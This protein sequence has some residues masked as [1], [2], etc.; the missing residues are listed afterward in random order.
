MAATLERAS[1]GWVESFET[2][3]HHTSQLKIRP[4]HPTRCV[5]PERSDLAAFLSQGLCIE[6]CD[7]STQRAHQ[8]NLTMAQ[9]FERLA[10]LKSGLP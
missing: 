9:H 7:R 4:T 3:Q 10:H 1:K 2:Y 5:L 8:A 6:D